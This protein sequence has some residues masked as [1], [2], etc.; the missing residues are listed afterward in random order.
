LN[1]FT[2]RSV[3]TIVPSK[4]AA[5]P[6]PPSPSLFPPPP[7]SLLFVGKRMPAIFITSPLACDC[8]DETPGACCSVVSAR[9]RLMQHRTLYDS[10][11]GRKP[12]GVLAGFYRSR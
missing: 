1:P 8:V 12:G 2:A 4:A 9:L 11:A 3:E 7:A 5:Y 6:S 10:A